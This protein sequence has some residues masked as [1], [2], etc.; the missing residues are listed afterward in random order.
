MTSDKEN[1]PFGPT[2]WMTCTN[3]TL[4]KRN[5]IQMS[6]YYMIPLIYV[7]TE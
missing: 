6:T 7:K 4:S 5:C 1:E 2:T 3:V